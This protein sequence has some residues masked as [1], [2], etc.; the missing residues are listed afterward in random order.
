MSHY[1]S[2][3]ALKYKIKCDEIFHNMGYDDIVYRDNT[4]YTYKQVYN[5]LKTA[6]PEQMQS[7]LRNL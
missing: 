5:W 2:A 4:T 1:I 3:E 6:T 7:K